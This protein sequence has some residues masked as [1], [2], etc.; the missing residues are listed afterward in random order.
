MRFG[1]RAQQAV[2]FALA[3]CVL[4]ALLGHAARLFDL[5]FVSQTDAVFY[6][7]KSRI[8]APQT[9]DDRI[10][11]VDI[12][13]RSLAELGR[14][15]WRRDLMA[16]I[17]DILFESYRIRAVGFD[18]VFAGSDQDPGMAVMDRVARIASENYPSMVK[19]IERLKPEFDRDGKFVNSLRGRPVA[20]GYF[21][22]QEPPGGENGQLPPALAGYGEFPSRVAKRTSYGANLPSIQQ[23]AA[24]AGHFNV[25]VDRD[26][27]SRRVPLLARYGDEVYES[28]ALSMLRL[29]DGASGVRLE[30]S[31]AGWLAA[32]ENRRFEWLQVGTGEMV[33][34]IPIDDETNALIPYRGPPGTFRYVSIADVA[35]RRL[36]PDMLRD[37]IVLVGTS[38]GGLLDLR[39]TPLSNT[40]VGV[41]MHANLLSGMLEGTIRRQPAWGAAFEVVL[42]IVVGALVRVT[43]PRLS[44]LRAAL[45]ALGMA[46]LLLGGNFV[47]WR[48]GYALPVA[49]SLLLV[50]GLLA[51]QMS[52]GYTVEARSRREFARLFGQYVPPELVVEMSRNPEHYSMEGQSKEL[53]VLFCDLRGFTSIAERLEPREVTML[54]GEFLTAMTA[55]IGRYRGTVDKFIGD[56]V[57][58]FWGAPVADPNH[59]REAVRA[60]I[61][62]QREIA[63]LSESLVARGFPALEMGVGINTGQVTV[64]DFGSMVRKSYT[65]IGDAVNL[66]S[67]LEGLTRS[68]GVGII[69]GEATRKAVR[70]FAW[71]ELDRVRVKGKDTAVTIFEPLGLRSQLDAAEV[72]SLSAWHGALAHYRAKRWTAA[73]AEMRNLARREP[74][75][76][77]YALYLER[78]ARLRME[79]PAADWDGVVAFDF[80]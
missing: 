27:V 49:S 2:T 1:N 30:H 76:A 73:E 42:L 57:M 60:A 68:Y 16:E 53:T 71:R 6:D 58:A 8:F 75:R 14:W 62:M 51:L 79:P 19:E 52:W 4:G 77:L 56:A 50:I 54:L 37:K 45:N 43:L 70:G 67:R 10:V 69:V 48:L 15:P 59:A 80:K 17:V 38:A 33:R 5:R 78:I 28:L 47:A 32:F 12:D 46:A 72:V 29:L 35:K 34:R 63:R 31:H 7:I 65:V 55:V 64:G 23:A 25:D 40:F 9:P 22:S 41:E 13:D 20:L 74:G 36:V 39:V 3:L 61:E 11:I 18:V 66:A 21:F 24:A 44:P 26:G